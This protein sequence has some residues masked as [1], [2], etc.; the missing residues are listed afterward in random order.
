MKN[1][2]SSFIVFITGNFIFLKNL[3]SKGACSLVLSD[4]K[5]TMTFFLSKFLSYILL[6]PGLFVWAIVAVFVLYRYKKKEI[7]KIVLIV[8]AVL[9]YLL[10]IDPLADLLLY[11]LENSHEALD[12]EG[13]ED[14]DY[15]S[16]I[17]LGGGLNRHAPELEEKAEETVHVPGEAMKRLYYAHFLYQKKPVDIIVAGG[18]GF[19]R[20]EDAS[21][22]EVMKEI[23]VNLGIPSEDIIME[24]KSRN[25]KEN[26]ENSKKIMQESDLQKALLITSAYHMPRSVMNAKKQDLDF[27][28]APTDYRTL[29][30]GYD[31]YSFLPKSSEFY[32]SGK[33]LREY[34]GIVVAWVF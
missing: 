2:L 23:L 32:N 3:Q 30:G 18:S 20:E 4:L 24:D 34:V 21:E 7:A 14:L 33:A 12:P 31:F 8:T 15:D 22:A 25:T 28:A 11:P 10:S 17:V 26:L 13:V 27:M 19:D 1:Y 5:Q 6:P 29:R 16:M 9:I